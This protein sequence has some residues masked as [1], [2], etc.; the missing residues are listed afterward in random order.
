MVTAD[1]I[2]IHFRVMWEG[3]IKK[4]PDPVPAGNCVT[5]DC[6]GTEEKKSRSF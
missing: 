6:D 2:R 1:R 5:P 3:K 4:V